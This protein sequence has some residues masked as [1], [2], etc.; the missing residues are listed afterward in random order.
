MILAL[1]LAVLSIPVEDVPV[2]VGASSSDVQTAYLWFADGH[3]HG[4]ILTVPGSI[5]PGQPWPELRLGGRFY[6]PAGRRITG[7][8]RFAATDPGS[9][10][11]GDVAITRE[12]T[13]VA[14][15]A[16]HKHEPLG[17]YDG[18]STA[19]FLGRDY[20]TGNGGPFYV[21]LVCRTVCGINVRCHYGV[22]LRLER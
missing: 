13:Y 16:P 17:V 9:C 4:R 19:G 8:A 7:W 22:R 3:E 11:E 14:Q 12:N 6:L 20:P 2:H 5:V 1:L 15:S 21:W 10:F 18:W